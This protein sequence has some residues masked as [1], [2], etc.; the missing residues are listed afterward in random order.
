MK[1]EKIGLAIWL[2]LVIVCS[3]N[4]S[5]SSSK[6]SDVAISDNKGGNFTKHYKKNGLF[7]KDQFYKK[8]LLRREIFMG[9][10]LMYKYPIKREDL[11]KTEFILSSG[12]DYLKTNV[13]DTLLFLNKG[14]PI[15]NKAI[16]AKGA[17]LTR[18]DENSYSIKS[19]MGS[20]NQVVFYLLVKQ[21][22]YGI[23][24]TEDFVADSLVI[25]I[26]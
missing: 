13:D 12:N 17:I 14:I 4:S 3:C 1:K 20:S 18:R 9:S 23:T 6:I 8:T 15:M 25:P 5:R 19:K 16:F 2:I 22:L 11:K 26:R 24:H 10:E 21:N 7:F